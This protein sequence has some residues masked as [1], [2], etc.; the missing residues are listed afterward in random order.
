ML[1]YFVLFL[2]TAFAISV[3]SIS[4]FGREIVLRKLYKYR[5]KC[6]DLR[7]ICT[8]DGVILHGFQLG[9][10]SNLEEIGRAHV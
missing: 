3:P 5:W 7:W 2:F 1:G 8:L 4:I 9:M 6:T 10:H